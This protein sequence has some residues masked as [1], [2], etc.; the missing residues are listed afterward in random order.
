[1]WFTETAWP[2]ILLIA[3]L[4]V[5]AAL[6]GS[7]RRQARYFLVTAACLASAALVWF[8]ERSIVTDRERVE[9][10]LYEIAAA[11]ERDDSDAVLDAISM[12]APDLKEMANMAL[13]WVQLRDLRVT[14][15]NVELTGLDRSRARAHFRVNGRVAI[16]TSSRAADDGS[17]NYG[18]IDQGHQATRWIGTWQRESDRWRLIELEQLDPITGESI[19]TIRRY[20]NR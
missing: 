1:M 20:L 2:P 7:E 10:G 9:E 18:A 6:L 12:H 14:D 19:R 11:F 4:G 5:I 13:N 17:F 8:L 3:T 15:V 16:H